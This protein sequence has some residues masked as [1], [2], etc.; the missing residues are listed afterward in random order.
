MLPVASLTATVLLVALA[1]ALR[2][3]VPTRNVA[4][5]V[6]SPVIAAAYTF[7]NPNDALPSVNVL[8]AAGTMPVA[9]QLC[10]RVLVRLPALV[11]FNCDCAAVSNVLYYAV[12][13]VCSNFKLANHLSHQLVCLRL[14][15]QLRL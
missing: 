14:G 7:E 9:V 3:S 6:A 13:S 2:K 1:L 8:S 10:L 15:F 12:V 4:A 11:T 5:L